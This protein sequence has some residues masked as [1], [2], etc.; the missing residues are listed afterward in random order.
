MSYEATFC[1]ASGRKFGS[2]SDLFKSDFNKVVRVQ[3]VSNSE[4]HKSNRFRLPGVLPPSSTLH[5]KK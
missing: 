4:T 5:L 1:W 2:S 3:L